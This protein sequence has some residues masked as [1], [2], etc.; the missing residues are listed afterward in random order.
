MVKCLASD[1]TIDS[2]DE[3]FNEL[4]HLRG[5]F[6]TI[7]EWLTDEEHVGHCGVGAIMDQGLLLAL[8]N[9][10]LEALIKTGRALAKREG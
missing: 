9:E 4:D 7:V 3:A 8:G 2:I 6:R 1:A 5:V 10:R